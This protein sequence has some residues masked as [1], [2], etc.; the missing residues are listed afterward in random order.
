MTIFEARVVRAITRRA[1]GRSPTAVVA[2]MVSFVVLGCG[3]KTGLDTWSRAEEGSMQFERLHQTWPLTG[4]VVSTQRPTLEWRNVES[5]R[6]RIELSRTRGF[7]RVEVQSVVEGSSWRPPERLAPGP[8]FWR[9][10]STTSE[11]RS[12]VWSFRAPIRDS[13]NDSVLNFVQDFNSDGLADVVA[14]GFADPVGF[15]GAVTY[16]H[17]GRRGS[18]LSDGVLV[19]GESNTDAFLYGS[20]TSVVDV[21]GLGFPGFVRRPMHRDYYFGDLLVGGEEGLSLG[22]RDTIPGKVVGVGDIDRDGLGDLHVRTGPPG[23]PE[24]WLFGSRAGASSRRATNRQDVRPVP[25]GVLST[26]PGAFPI[27]F[28]GDRQ[29][30]L[31]TGEIR[32]DAVVLVVNWGP[33]LR[34][35]PATEVRLDM[36]GFMAGTRL[37]DVNGDGY[38]DT[39]VMG[40]SPSAA[41]V[42]GGATLRAERFQFVTTVAERFSDHYLIGIGDVNGDGFSDAV[43]QPL[44]VNVNLRPRGLLVHY[45]SPAGLSSEPSLEIR[46]APGSFFFGGGVCGCGDLD[47]DGLDDLVVSDWNNSDRALLVYRGSASGLPTQPSYAVAR[48]TRTLQVYGHSIG[49]Q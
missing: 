2:G 15:T 29:M 8:W 9:L 18:T 41:V 49:V 39:G 28:N 20:A 24:Y 16:V 30:D 40:T 21:V 38:P 42:Y 22:V 48:P 37:G 45:G 7:E 26:G 19:A 23:S 44:R 11:L 34:P 33:L 32:R 4:Y 10:S 6:T 25:G 31:L 5:S 36:S 43:Q 27:D 12:A 35:S 1:A 47:G 13:S 46:G 17:F 3:A 14:F